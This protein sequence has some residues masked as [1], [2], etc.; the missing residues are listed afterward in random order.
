MLCNLVMVQNVVNIAG[1]IKIHTNS[2]E[3]SKFLNKSSEEKNS[4]HWSLI[5]RVY[6]Q[7]IE[8][9]ETKLSSD[10]KHILFMVLFSTVPTV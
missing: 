10:D 4:V 1:S 3:I 5:L 2:L 9:I 8:K 7:K 6:T